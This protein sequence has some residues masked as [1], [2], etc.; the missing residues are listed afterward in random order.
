MDAAGWDARYAGSELVWGGEPN[1]FVAAELDGLRPGHALDL[2]CGEGRNAI[3]LAT[4]GWNV[5]GVDF[6]S[7]A[8]GRARRLAADAGVAARTDFIVGDVVAGPVPAGPFDAVVLAYL[9]LPATERRI[10]VRQAARALGPGGTLLVVAHDTSNL[11]DGVGGPQD[12]R[13]L[14]SAA[15]V[16]ADLDG[17]PDLVVEKAERVPRSVQTPNGDRDAI[18]VLVRVR[19]AREARVPVGS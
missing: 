16:L 8:I 4:R 11:T 19:M 6:S 13:V 3:W 14:Y 7:A 5:T 18:D 12:A 2:A 17:L 1:R 10:A 9:Q 15:D